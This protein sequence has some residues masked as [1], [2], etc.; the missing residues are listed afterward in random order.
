MTRAEYM[1][2]LQERLERF[3]KELQEEI[4][5]DYRQHF[6]EG[7]KQGKSDEEI[8]KELGNIEEMIEEMV[9]DLP[10]AEAVMPSWEEE[11]EK[12]YTYS[13]EF[14]EVVLKGGVADVIVE[15][16]EDGKLKVDYKN[17][18]RLGSQL[19]YE[20]HQYQENGVFHAE[21]R[22][23]KDVEDI[24][25]NGEKDGELVKLKLFGKTIISYGNVASFSSEKGS[26]VLT[27]K[28]PKGMP[29]L[30]ASV[31]SGDIS[32]TGIA[33]EEL[34]ASSAS[35]NIKL[36]EVE[37]GKF[38]AQTASGDI[39]ITEGSFRTG[40]L[41]TA[42]GD[43]SLTDSNFQSGSMGTASGNINVRGGHIGEVKYTTASG[44][45]KLATEAESYECNTASGNIKVKAAGTPA[46]A[47]LNTAS[48]NIQLG[49]ENVTG[50]EVT[51][52]TM[53][54]NAKV[55]WKDETRITAKKGTF[56]YGDG[57]CKVTIKSVS[58]NIG[59]QCV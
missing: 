12:S 54:G 33:P 29:K 19:K 39:N 8:I 3:G 23:R 22:R 34:K 16:S 31:S 57:A 36:A 10:E 50:V 52:R 25:E 48:G 24:E 15:P 14:K 44:N 18:G 28:V 30:N 41:V 37:A 4:L 13:E 1:E 20:F 56:R 45:I 58:G 40:G 59:V 6:A 51:V 21:V 27:V 43:I 17:N 5:E 46:K 55:A 9:Q 35:G 32:M 26:I 11:P 49:L 38:N 47:S 42:S 2:K 7:E 53:S